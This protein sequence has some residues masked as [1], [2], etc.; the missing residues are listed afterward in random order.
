MS[1][2][3]VSRRLRLLPWIRAAGAMLC[4][5]CVVA[6]TGF[7]EYA[8]AQSSVIM[9]VVETVP[10]R[11]GSDSADDPAIWIHPT[12][13]SK[14]VIIGADKAEGVSGDKG[15][16]T[17][18]DLNGTEIQFVQDGKTNN[19]DLRYHFPFNG[20]TVDLV[21]ATNQYHDSLSIFIMNP[22]TRLLEPVAARIIQAGMDVYGTCM[23]RSPTTGK[24]YQFVTSESGVV[25]QWHLF[26]NRQGKVDAVKVDQFTARFEEVGSLPEG[27][28]A[29][30]F[31]GHLYISGTSGLWKYN[32]EPGTV[33]PIRKVDSRESGRLGGDLEGVAIY[34]LDATTGYI[35][36][37]DQNRSAFA[38]YQRE[39]NN[40]FITTFKIRAN[41]NLDIDEVSGTDGID[42]T[43]VALGAAFPHGVFV[44][45]DTNNTATSNP[46]STR[47]KS[48][49]KLVRWDDI[50]KGVEPT[51]NM[52]TIWNPRHGG[53]SDT[54][55]PTT[56][57][58]T[59]APT[60]SP[61]PTP[62]DRAGC[63]PATAE[64]IMD[65]ILFC[66]WMAARIRTRKAT[67]AST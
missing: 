49:Y 26:D 8:V 22:V 47:Y 25:Q 33:R 67:C 56:P 50:A 16:L 5:I 66:A 36:V 21:T 12:D 43:N 3:A 23:Y 64:G 11:N 1:Q 7:I 13:P 19:V 52:S 59:P 58:P 38:V 29:D 57:A 20:K 18:Y 51:L 62:T 45:H 30:D 34:H 2:H 9:P 42:V 15:G 46:N 41:D 6:V 35:L 4:L 53:S 39:G 17:V 40:D 55:S 10:T 32:A 14:S 27:C 28:V 37:S 65:Q 24:Y 44:A 61:T 60:P 31:Y 48:N 54:P 63:P